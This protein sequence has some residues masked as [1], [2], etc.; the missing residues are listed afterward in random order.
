MLLSCECP[1]K[2]AHVPGSREKKLILREERGS[3]KIRWEH[4][5]T[6]HTLWYTSTCARA[7][8]QTCTQTQEHTA[9]VVNNWWCCGCLVDAKAPGRQKCFCQQLP[10]RV[11]AWLLLCVC[12]TRAPM[13][14]AQAASLAVSHK[15]SKSGPRH[16][17]SVSSSSPLI[18]LDWSRA[19][20]TCSVIGW[21]WSRWKIFLFPFL[22][23]L[24]CSGK[25]FCV[26]VR[27]YVQSVF[28]C[29][30]VRRVYV[31]CSSMCE[32]VF[33]FVCWLTWPSVQYYAQAQVTSSRAKH[34]WKTEV[35]FH[36]SIHARWVTVT[37]LKRWCKYT[38]TN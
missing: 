29:V 33:V 32:C 9:E 7:R 31:A 3:P 12:M 28:V 5:V 2:Q 15:S 10:N 8:T 17:R 4:I 13:W 38:K 35:S 25:W 19:E 27:V 23:F 6:K 14:R 24:Q 21:H 11:A 1:Q 18:G 30:H 37:S 20:V 16:E 34:C 26:Y 36:A 22:P